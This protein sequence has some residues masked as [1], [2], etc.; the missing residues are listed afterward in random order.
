MSLPGGG[1]EF[2]NGSAREHDF[3]LELRG[4]WKSYGETHALRDV[5]LGVRRGRVLAVLGPN[6]AGKSTL[7]RVAAGIA[8][9]NRGD[10]RI[11]G[12]S[13]AADGGV[14]R[15]VGFAGHLSFLYGH[16]TAEENLRF[17]SRLYGSDPGHA[18]NQLDRFGLMPYR[19]RPVRTLSRGLVQRVSLARA[20]L[21]DPQVVLLD[22]PF[23]GLDLEAAR[24]F[25]GAIAD[26]RGRGRAVIMATHAWADAQEFAD[27]AVVLVG[28]RLALQDTASALDRDRLAALYQTV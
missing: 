1:S 19:H 17:Y 20:L 13:L 7:L 14:R 12:R 28:G 2:S 16:L 23:T 22:E 26:L 15:L 3:A 10:V 5:W 4:V 11:D 25:H 6:G 8:R 24:M 9:P 27:E 18:M 21:H